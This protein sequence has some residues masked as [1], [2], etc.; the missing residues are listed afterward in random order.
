MNYIF[1]ISLI[2]IC[3]SMSLYLMFGRQNTIDILLGIFNLYLTTFLITYY[4]EL[5]YQVSFGGTVLVVFGSL[6]FVIS[7]SFILV[8]F[9]SYKKYGNSNVEG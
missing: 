2:M 6:F 5:R 7:L 4:L 9:E 3:F 1:L 8:R